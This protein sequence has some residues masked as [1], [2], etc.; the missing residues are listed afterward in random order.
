MHFLDLRVSLVSFPVVSSLSLRPTSCRRIHSP[1]WP[2][3]PYDSRWGRGAVVVRPLAR[4]KANRARFPAGSLPG[5]SH[6]GIVPDSA[7]CRRVLSGISRSC[8]FIPA[9]L[10]THPLPS[11]AFKNN[12][13]RIKTRLEEVSKHLALTNPLRLQGRKIMQGDMH[14]GKEV[15]GSHG[16]HFGAVTTSLSVLRVSLNYEE[17]GKNR[18]ERRKNPC[19]R[20]RMRVFEVSME[21]RRNE[22]AGKTGDPRENSLLVASSGTILTCEKPGNDPAGDYGRLVDWGRGF[23]HGYYAMVR[24]QQCSPTGLAH[25]QPRRNPLGRIGSPGVDLSGAAKIHCSTHGMVAR[26]MAANPRGCPGNTRR[27][28]ARQGGCCYSPKRW[29][30]EILTGDNHRANIVDSTAV[31]CSTQGEV[32]SSGQKLPTCD[33]PPVGIDFSF[34]KRQ[35]WN[36]DGG[37]GGMVCLLRC[38]LFVKAEFPHRIHPEHYCAPRNWEMELFVARACVRQRRI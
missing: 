4:T 23:E 22:G 36:G 11:S 27:E 33:Y 1:G 31:T 16:L 21:Q 14:R 35:D 34:R 5:F 38:W 10:H 25:P 8:P 20:K 32:L 26:G 2:G 30:Y 13:S 18:Q 3:R 28:H 12:T 9:P 7:S 37:G 24:R 19:D 17:Q 15:L 6:A 29:P